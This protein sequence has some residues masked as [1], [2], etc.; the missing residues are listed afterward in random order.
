MSKVNSLT[1]G[2]AAPLDAARSSSDRRHI[3]RLGLLVGLGGITMLFAAFTS[4]YI[5]RSGGGDWTALELPPVLWMSTALIVVSS[6]TLEMAR[7]AFRDRNLASFRSWSAATAALGT[8]F[9]VSQYAAWLS[10]NEAGVYLQSHPKSSFFFVLTGV[11]AAH[12]LAG[13][14]ALLALFG[15]AAAGRLVP[16]RS[17]APTLTAIYWHFVGGLWIYLLAVLSLLG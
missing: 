15:L 9:L 7:R 10:L 5:V 16:G 4:A 6:L 3:N 1:S 14:V 11:H 17:D 13:V 12:L 2:I 8:G